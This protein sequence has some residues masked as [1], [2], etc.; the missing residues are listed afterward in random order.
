MK[1][2]AKTWVAVLDGA[3][4]LILVNEGT[5]VAPQLALRRRL[6]QDN[7]PSREQG[8]DQPGRVHESMGEHRSSVE[9]PDPHQKA[10][11]RFVSQ[12]AADLEIDAA[13]G[14]FDH[15][16]IVA[17]PVALGVM[18][19]AFGAEL[20]RRIAKEIAAD[21]TKHPLPAITAAIEKALELK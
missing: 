10:E 6:A 7:P 8:R 16:V 5:A 18:R 17:P 9:A 12:I 20:R 21:Y 14:H 11:D 4:G 3:H 13:A 2:A 1:L 15:I 19:K